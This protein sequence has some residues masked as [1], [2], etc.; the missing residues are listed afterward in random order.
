LKITIR[1]VAALVVLALIAPMAAASPVAQ[2]KDERELYGRT[3]LEPLASYNYI[4]LGDGG[5]GEFEG[6]MKLLEKLFPRY[7]DF[8]TVAEQ[9]G[10][11]HA[12]SVGVDGLPS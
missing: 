4:Q 10:N 12:V 7:L 11:K 1:V 3:F 8:T 2:T 5:H 6:G 9:L